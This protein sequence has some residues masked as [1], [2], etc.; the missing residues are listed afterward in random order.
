MY[1]IWLIKEENN[2]FDRKKP[3]VITLLRII[4]PSPPIYHVLG[5]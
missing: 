5:I 3:I 4:I 2:R 1:Y